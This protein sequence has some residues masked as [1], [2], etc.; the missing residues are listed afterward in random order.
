MRRAARARPL[1]RLHIAPKLGGL[2]LVEITTPRLRTWRHDLLGSIGPVTAAKAYRLLRAVL[3]TAVTDRLITCNPCQIVGA[4]QE[5]SPERPIATMNQVLTIADNVPA[6][7][8][9]MVLLACFASM[10][11]GE[12]AA[13]ARKHVNTSTGEVLIER[14]M[15]EMVNGQLVFGPPKSAAGVRVVTVPSAILSALTDHLAEFTA[16]GAEALVFVGPMGAAV[17]RSNFQ[18]HWTKGTT[19]AGVMGLHF[20][21][22]RHT[23]NTW[24]AESGAT[25]RDLMDR[26]GHASTKAAL[27]YLH[28]SGARDRAIADALS[29]MVERAQ[30]QKSK[31]EGQPEELT[32]AADDDGHDQG[33]GH[34]AGT[35]SG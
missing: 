6:R 28:R 21:D 23:G 4:G 17:R 27:I 15:G 12:L 8:R 5:K 10:R 33:D 3:N 26:M 22:L 13:L 35:T 16:E 29:G 18:E 11:F 25:L 2:A 1:L 7:F 20:H 31:D 19:A 32:V 9:A 30:A 24:A 34:A 14:T